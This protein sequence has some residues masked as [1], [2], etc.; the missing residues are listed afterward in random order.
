MSNIKGNIEMSYSF[1]FPQPKML[2]LDLFFVMVTDAGGKL[3][4][5][6]E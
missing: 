5:G 6:R 2:L 3:G 1:A 4:E